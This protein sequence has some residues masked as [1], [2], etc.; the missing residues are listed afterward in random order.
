[1]IQNGLCELTR[2]FDTSSLSS[3]P[4]AKYQID[5]VVICLY[6]SNSKYQYVNISILDK[7][8][9]SGGYVHN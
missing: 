2:P 7:L 4:L 3:S 6:V 1:M 9:S 5:R 8:F